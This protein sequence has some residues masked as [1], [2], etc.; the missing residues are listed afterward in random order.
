M[1]HVSHHCLMSK[2]GVNTRL[3][4]WVMMLQE[5]DAKICD[6]KGK[7]NLVV[8]HLSRVHEENPSKEISLANSLPDDS[9]MFIE[10]LPWFSDMVNYKSTNL[11]PPGLDYQ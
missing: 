5:F 9:L 8:D 4:Y 10:A 6:K 7:E 2:K 3:I 1:D 11:T